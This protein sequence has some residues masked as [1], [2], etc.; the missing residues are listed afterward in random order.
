MLDPFSG[1]FTTCAVGKE[2]GRRTIGIEQE[3]DYVKIGLRRLAIREHWN[4]E[5]LLRPQ[6]TYVRRNGARPT[7]PLSPEQTP[8]L[9]E[10]QAP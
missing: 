6:K 8:G 1:T 3:E 2:L 4:G 10:G 5:P 9:F 7:K